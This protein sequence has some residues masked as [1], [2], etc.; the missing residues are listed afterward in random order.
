MIGKWMI[1]C[2][3][4]N[5]RVTVAQLVVICAQVRIPL[6]IHLFTFT[7]ASD[8]FDLIMTNSSIN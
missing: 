6:E 1:L 8:E 3:V 7:F 5:V 4:S 2:V